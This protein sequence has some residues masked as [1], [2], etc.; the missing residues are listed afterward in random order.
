MRG[1][2]AS[3]GRTGYRL[4]LT[5]AAGGIGAVAI[6]AI[7]AL[8][9]V[10]SAGIS[11][12][13]VFKGAV[14]SPS[15][16]IDVSGCAKA[17]GALP[18][19][20]KLTGDGKLASTASAATCSKARGGSTFSSYAE[21]EP[22]LTVKS[23]VKIPS[24]TGGVNVT[25]NIVVAGSDSA[26]VTSAGACPVAYSYAY[27]INYGYT[28]FNYSYSDSYCSVES[29]IEMFGEAY[30][31]NVT[32]GTQIYPNNYWDLFNTSGAYYS[33]YTDK[34]SY[35]NSSYW[36][37]NYSYAYTSNYSYGPSGSISGT[38]NPT[39]FINSTFS[40]SAKYAVYTYIGA[41]VYVEVQ[42]YTG[43]GA[44][45]LNGATGPNH[46]DLQHFAVW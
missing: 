14:W 46:V 12:P 8:S 42:G 6:V 38:Y 44:A 24:G 31:Q 1:K 19:W 33:N 21:T 17:A 18:H 23:P 11:T 45:S 32:G 27:S 22:E 13:G 9:S 15:N 2:S 35:S 39:W 4:R 3:N 20:S 43:H 34:G 25:W 28:W 26:A 30:V 37:S 41:F 36:A 29:E 5:A 16:F 7:M 10:A 40:H